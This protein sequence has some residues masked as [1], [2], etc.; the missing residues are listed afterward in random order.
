MNNPY[1]DWQ[2][3]TALVFFIL[4]WAGYAFFT[5]KESLSDTSLL[6]VTNRFRMQWMR[7]MLKRDNRSVDIIMVGNLQRSITFFANTTIFIVAGLMTMLN[8]HDRAES[9]F[10]SIPFSKPM[11]GFLW[12]AKLFVLIIIFIYAFFKYTWSLR[13]Y[14]YAGIFMSAAPAH[15]DHPETH[16]AIIAKGSYLV[17]NAAKHF[18]LGLRAYYFGLA[19][20]A[21]F[22]HPYLFM[23]ATA[24]VIFV[25]HRR[26]Y[27]SATLKNLAQ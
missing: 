9:I 27:R 11:S 4:C 8:Y 16:D 12:E 15:D 1:M 23:A 26:E 7:E 2:E 17:G 3:V 6:A 21:W 14:N 5:E 20:L 10:S 25:T 13:Q 22:I 24:W 18:N 19:A